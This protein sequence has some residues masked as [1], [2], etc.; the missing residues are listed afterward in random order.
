MTLIVAYLRDGRLSE[1]RDESRKLRIK[2][3]KYVLIDEVEEVKAWVVYTI[4]R[5]NRSCIEIPRRR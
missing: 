1:E 3:V 4:C 2:S 5:R